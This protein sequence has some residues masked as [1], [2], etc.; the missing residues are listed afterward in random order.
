MALCRTAFEGKK[1]L[2]P[3]RIRQKENVTATAASENGRPAIAWKMAGRI[4]IGAAITRS[5]RI[6]AIATVARARW[7][8]GEFRLRGRRTRGDCEP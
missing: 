3:N 4:I 5:G 2:P 1:T 7:G 8:L 6:D